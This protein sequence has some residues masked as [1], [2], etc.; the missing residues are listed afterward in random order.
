M[1]PKV[2]VA[3]TKFGQVYLES[4]SRPGFPFELAGIL[5]QGSER[6][7]ACARHYGV[8]LY[9]EVEKIPEDVE[10]ACVVIRGG[11][12]GGP[13]AEVAQAL[14][15]RGLHVLQEHPLH[16]D[17]LAQCLRTAARAGVVY[18]LNSFYVHTAP[19]RRLLRA[20]AELRARQKLRYVDAACGFQVAYALLDIVGQATGGVRPWA[21]ADPA[22]R[23]P[24][25]AGLADLDV[26][27]RAVDGVIGGVPLTLRV[28]NQLDPADPDNHAHLLHRITLG[29]EGGNLTL[30]GTHGP[31]L[32][33]P[34][35][36]FPQQV[37]DPTTGAV[38]FAAREG[39]DEHLDVP[40][41]MPLDEPVA[42]SY[43]RVF[44][45]VWPEGVE[46][47][48][49]ELRDA[50]RSGEASLRRGQYHLT[51]CTM[52]QDLTARLGPPELLH[53]ATHPEPLKPAAVEALRAAATGEE[54]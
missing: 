45:T 14:M 48:L 17:E 31:T 47:A 8:P 52:W 1:T 13:G 26:P 51:L 39:G 35:P 53:G 54:A 44:D 16:H 34:R 24:G 29:T 28:Q 49:T 36:D 6:S 42:P 18:H 38:H 33:S 40:S 2:L 22:P 11:L 21:F 19:V 37:Q 15:R 30:V 4:F 23:V 32:W 46:H 50:A 10:F 43:R 12:L 5:A 20:A 3:G 41:V 27:F 7:Q 25:L 9:T